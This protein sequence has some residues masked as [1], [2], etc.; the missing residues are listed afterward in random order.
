MDIRACLE[1]AVKK[2]ASDL[3]IV[4]GIPP[5][6]RVN[7]E[8]VTMKAESVTP[9]ASREA[10]YGI[11]DLD[12]RGM[13]EKNM[14][15]NFAYAIPELGRFRVNVYVS[16]GNVEAAFRIIAVKPR[17]IEE[18]GLPAI[19]SELSRKASGLVLITGAAGQ[20]KTTTLASMID[21]INREGRKYRIVTIEDP[22]EYQHHNQNS[23]II[24]REVGIDTR[25]FNSALVQSL[26]QDPNIICIGELRDL[27]TISTAL[28]AAETGHLV[29]A[30]L[31]TPDAPQCVDRVVDV[32]PSHQQQQ[33]RYQ[34]ASCLEGVI[35]QKLLPRK[36]G[37]GVA[38]V[39][40]ALI[41]TS[42]VRNL[43]RENKIE[44]LYGVMQTGSAHGMIFM[45]DAL[46]ALLDREL[47]T[48]ELAIARA[49]DPRNLSES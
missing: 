18:L 44:Q 4:V 21:L 46:K 25:S 41:G 47:I 35:A 19:V 31:H 2:K 11:L 5:T 32:F 6:L 14:E 38:V 33:I 24:Q 34:L 29:L 37:K 40:E 17:P 39:V 22:I 3:H 12:Q 15:L 20:G 16:R 26:R 9:R 23:V 7:G 27:E 49:R 42:A 13:F 8:L 28:T 1:E 36:D 10:L 30:T 45:D 48:H 43:I